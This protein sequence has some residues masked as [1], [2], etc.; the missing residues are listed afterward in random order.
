MNI[1]INIDSDILVETIKKSMCKDDIFELIKAL[2]LRVAEYDFTKR[3]QDYFT[4]QVAIEDAHDQ[5]K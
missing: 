3:L 4:E 5:D 1:E 2:D